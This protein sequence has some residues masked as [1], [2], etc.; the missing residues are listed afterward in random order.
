MS[1]C[2]PSSSSTITRSATV[3]MSCLAGSLLEEAVLGVN[4]DVFEVRR[5]CCM[6]WV[7]SS[8]TMHHAAKCMKCCPDLQQCVWSVALT[9]SNVYEVSPWPAKNICVAAVYMKCCPMTSYY[10]V[11]CMRCGPDLK[12]QCVLSLAPTCISV[13]EMLPQPATWSADPTCSNG[14]CPMT[15]HHAAM[16]MKC[17]HDCKWQGTMHQCWSVCSSLKWWGTMRHCI[18]SVAQWQG[19]MQQCLS[20]VATTLKDRAW[21]SSVHEV[22]L[23][24]KAVCMKCCPDLKWQGTMQQCVLSVNQ[25]LNDFL[26]FHD[27]MI[28]AR[29]Q[30]KKEKSTKKFFSNPHWPTFRILNFYRPKLTMFLNNKSRICGDISV[31]NSKMWMWKVW[32]AFRKIMDKSSLNAVITDNNNNNKQTKLQN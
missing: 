7:S 23:G 8:V 24:H 1:I 26:K 27:L 3:R 28:I 6:D 18:W 19:I 15:M 12:W 9:C 25:T 5:Y 2:P 17:C 11:L 32:K 4:Q 16:C 31:L 13:Y 14:C 22:F 20:N 10:A 30:L 21:C 29:K